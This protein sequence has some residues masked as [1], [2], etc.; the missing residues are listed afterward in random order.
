MEYHSTNVTPLQ[1]SREIPTV[2]SSL[3]TRQNTSQMTN[4]P[5]P[6]LDQSFMIKLD[7]NNF[8]IYGFD[9]I[10]DGT[11]PWPPHFLLDPNS[12]FAT[13]I[14]PIVVNPKYITWQYQNR[15]VMSWIY[16]L[17][18]E[19]MMTQIMSYNTTHE[20]RESLRCSFASTS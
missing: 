12:T 5:F 13:T 17:L 10:L 4:Q 15:L 19:P 11:L 7:C 8:L 18:T 9:D 1:D 14:K 16:F 3:I 6:S 20:I 2:G